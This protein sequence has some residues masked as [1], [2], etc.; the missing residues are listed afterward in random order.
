[1]SVEEAREFVREKVLTPF[2]VEPFLSPAE[3]SYL[4]N[5]KPDEQEMTAFSWQYENLYVMEWALGLIEAGFP[6]S[7]L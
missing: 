3:R 4:D 5:P 2:G 1:M 6:G 7:Y